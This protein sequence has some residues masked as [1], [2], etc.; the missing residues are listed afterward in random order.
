[1]TRFFHVYNRGV[2]KRKVF[3]NDKDRVRFLHDLYEFNNKQSSNGLT[4]HHLASSENLDVRR[5]DS[6]KKRRE[7]VVQI[8][9]FC[10]M[11]N[12]YHLLVSPID[13]DMENLSLFMKKLGGGYTK[14]FNEKYERN[15]A[16]WQGKYK[17]V[18]IATDAHFLYL[19]FYIHF[20]PLDLNMPKWRKG[21]LSNCREAEEYLQS[22]RWSSHSDYLG[23]KNFPSITD[24]KFFLDLLGGEEGYEKQMRALL[25]SRSIMSELEGITLE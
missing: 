13:D 5:Q 6:W 19:P 14:A 21:S 20:N 10:L 25:K 18:E 3:L 15:G 7:P 16:L 22:Y 2:D 23:K 4:K 17:K 1:M 24:R 8:H 12:H 11:P 9:C